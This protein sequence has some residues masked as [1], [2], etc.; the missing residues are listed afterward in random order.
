M[1]HKQTSKEGYKEKYD[2]IREHVKSVLRRHPP[3]RSNRTLCWYIICLEKSLNVHM[4]R[5]AII[6]SP[7]FGT[8]NRAM[9]E[10]QNENGEYQAPEDVEKE[11][12]KKQQ[13]MKETFGKDRRKR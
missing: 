4:D 5:T 6:E 1:K 3:A 13:A 11:R 10:I 2:T 7:N 9:R 8:L 12:Q